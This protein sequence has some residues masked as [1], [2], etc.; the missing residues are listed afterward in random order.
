MHLAISKTRQI[1]TVIL[2]GL[3]MAMD[4]YDLAAMPLAAPYVLDEIPIDKAQLGLIF[5]A[6]L[7][8]LGL[9]AVGLAPLGDKFGRRP[10]ILFFVIAIAAC[11]FGTSLSGSQN[12]FIVWRFLTGLFLGGCLPN[13]PALA[14]EVAP[15]SMKARLVTLTSCGIT[16][17][18]IFAGILV[19]KI[20]AVSGWRGIFV[21]PS[22]LFIILCLPIWFI[23]PNKKSTAHKIDQNKP[24][25]S[26]YSLLKTPNH[27]SNLIILSTIYAFNAFSIYAIMSW[28]PTILNSIG[29]SN[30]SAGQY[31]SL[32]Q[33]GGL[34]IGLS[35]SW[36]LDRHSH[37][38]II[39][40]TFLFIAL[41]Y[42][43]FSLFP[44]STPLSLGIMLLA[45]AGSVAGVHL[46]LTSVAACSF[47]ANVLSSA[48]GIMVAIARIGAVAGPIMAG[49]LID[50]ASKPENLFLWM[51]APAIFCLLISLKIPKNDK[52]TV[53]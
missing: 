19:S 40:A 16:L 28:L 1:G 44:T 10:I 20:E 26:N 6:I 43:S 48:I 36:I 7:L 12:S 14:S 13:V 32:V 42:A 4:G 41:S 22:L 31:L 2:C 8:G 39:T 3:I 25:I 30:A 35:L 53:L 18:A 46:V 11:T 29:I 24:K 21:M 9:G 15:P 23:L 5:S 33:A 50:N 49:Y 17:G 45:S 52:K 38:K 27:R 37:K 34:I 51:T 47:P